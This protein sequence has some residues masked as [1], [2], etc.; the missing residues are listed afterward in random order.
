MTTILSLSNL[1]LLQIITDIEDNADIICL[2]FTCKQLYQNSS[3]KRS[4][5]FKGIGEPINTEKRKISKQF[6]ETVNRFNLYS[7]KDILVNS[8][9]DQQVI[10]GKDRVTVYAEKNNRVDKSNIT[11]VLV[12][13]YQLETIQSIYQI[14]S[15]KT[16]FINDQT[17]EKAYFKVH[18]SSI[19]LL[20]NLQRL[21]VRSYDLD[22]GQHS[23]L[24][25]LDL[26]VGELYNLSVLE[27][28]F[29]S[30]TEL[31]IK[32]DFISSGRI[33]L[34]PS[35]LTSLTLEPLGI[36]PKN[37][38][39]SLTLLVK[40]DIYLDFGSQ[41]EEQPCIDLFCLNKLETLKLGGNDSE[42]YINYIIEI[43]LPP[44]IKNLVLIPTCISIPSECP[45]P[46]L[47]QLKVPQCL[48]TK[49]GFSMSSSPL[50]KKLVIDSCFE[51][52]EAKMI[53]SSLEHLS[54]DKNTGGANILDQVVFPTTLTYLSLKGSWIETVNPNRLPESLVKLKQ[55]IKGPVLPTLPQHL[56]QFIWKAQPYLYYKPLLVFPSTN[57]Y[58]PHLETLN[59]LEVH[60]D[61]TINVPLITKYLLIPL[62]A[63][64]STDD[65]QFY[66]LGSKISKSII[67]QPQWLPV[68]TTHLTCQLWNA[69]KDKKLGFRLDEIINRTNVRYLS[70]RMISRQKP[71]SA[72]FEF[73]IQR[74]D[75]D[76]RNVLVLERQSLTGGI[77]TQRKSIDSGQQYDPIYLYLN[78]SFGWSFG[79]EHIQ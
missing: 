58:P 44:S 43:Q 36:P 60:K 67:L 46:L 35:S 56:K 39:H 40:L 45:M 7:F 72:P 14:P 3:L 49:G 6:I 31:C 76:N 47:E 15:I 41:V 5:Q 22:I 13:E 1:L 16:L 23:S 11:T 17:N 69:S 48:F 65:T 73:S 30:L 70:L 33:N 63:V 25:S 34:L 42:H 77:I 78:R 27:N 64:H 38:F 51:N 37:A 74:L 28:K 61:F 10:L 29:E 68:N 4:I 79:K 32:S 19:S 21:F 66:S 54:I 9:S 18:L 62:D 53:P 2:L 55:N 50:L 71:A 57:N 24:K 12:K 8:L 75:P 20:P 52:V 59:L 26:H